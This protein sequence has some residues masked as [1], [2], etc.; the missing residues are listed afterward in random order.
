MEVFYT[1]LLYKNKDIYYS[2]LG[3]L[4]SETSFVSSTFSKTEVVE[5]SSLDITVSETLVTMNKVAIIAVALVK[6]LPADL[7]DIKLS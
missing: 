2:D 4:G 5:N 1:K 6:T 7:E 3:I